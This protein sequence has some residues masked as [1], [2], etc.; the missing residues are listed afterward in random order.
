MFARR[1][2]R[3]AYASVSVSAS[4]VQ[5]LSEDASV[6]TAHRA[7]CFAAQ[8]A[9]IRNVAL[10]VRA[11]Q[12]ALGRELRMTSDA[13]KGYRQIKEGQKGPCTP[14]WAKT[15]NYLV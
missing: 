9:E 10:Q 3:H 1:V 13:E 15:A 5:S 2:A 12:L 8:D 14:K 4:E 7:W 11:E 6:D